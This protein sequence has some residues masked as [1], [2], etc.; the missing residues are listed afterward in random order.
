M[1]FLY[2]GVRLPD[3]YT[4]YTPEVQTEKPHVFIVEYEMTIFG[5]HYRQATLYA[6]PKVE[7]SKADNGNWCVSTANGCKAWKIHVSLTGDAS[8]NDYVGKEWEAI[9]DTSS[10]FGIVTS[11]IDWA[12]FDV[13]NEDGTLC[14]AASEPI[15][16]YE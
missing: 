1:A 2:N 4:V 12:N 6:I 3:I 16:I 8:A 5:N 11:E 7:H 13:L 9:E 14:L 10:F 15:P